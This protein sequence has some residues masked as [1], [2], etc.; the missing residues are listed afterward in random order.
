MHARF[1]W[2]GE[3]SDNPLKNVC[4]N[5]NKL[6][7]DGV[8]LVVL[9]HLQRRRSSRNFGETRVEREEGWFLD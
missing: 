7:H 6:A 8:H 2:R 5:A 4:E 3:K 1:E 9:A